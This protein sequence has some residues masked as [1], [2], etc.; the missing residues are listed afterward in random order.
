[1]LP[2]PFRRKKVPIELGAIDAWG[3]MRVSTAS[4]VV[5]PCSP[6]SC[7][8]STRTGVAVD[9]RRWWWPEPVTTTG[10]RLYVRLVID[11]SR[12]SIL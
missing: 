12:R 5:M 1:M 10:F 8:D 2:R 6:I 7:D 4:N 3:I 9:F 11:E